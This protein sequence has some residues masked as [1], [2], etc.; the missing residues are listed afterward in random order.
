MQQIRSG[1]RR[2]FAGL[3]IAVASLLTSGALLVPA[4]TATTGSPDL[5]ITK[6][7]DASGALSV[8]D[9][10]SYIIT[11][12][13]DGT[14]TA[15]DVVITDD[16][17]TGIGVTAP[18]VQIPGGAC[19]VASSQVPPAP[20]AVSLYCSMDTL[21]AGSSVRIEVPVQVHPYVRCGS[22]A[23]TAVVRASDEPTVNR[24]NNTGSTVDTVTCAPSIQLLTTAP[25]YAHVGDDVTITMKV[26]N[27]GQLPLGSVAMSNPGCSPTLVSDGDGDATLGVG[28][29]WTYRCARAVGGGTSD[30]LT[31]VATVTAW[32]DSEQQV[33]ARDGASVRILGPGIS[34]ALRADPVSGSPGDTI[35]YSYIVTNTGDALLTDISVTDDR[36]GRIGDIPQLQP[37]HSASL[38]ADR[39]LSATAVWVTNTA[40]ARGT[41]LGGRVVTDT[42]EASITIVAGNAPGAGGGDGTA[43]TGLDATSAGITAMVL[44]LAGVCLLVGAARRRT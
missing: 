9:P 12:A 5:T 22:L 40:T 1:A 27:D 3:G 31:S 8:G 17:P 44:A 35:T 38:Q 6:S 10:F 29:S 11:A 25:A 42:D 4:A 26:R 43:F 39:V 23:N 37:G 18:V 41:D 19:A 7:S 15:H 28:E 30:P 14:A 34:V 33:S 16:F 32:T 36:L 2:A 20:P 13:N 24:A 21:A